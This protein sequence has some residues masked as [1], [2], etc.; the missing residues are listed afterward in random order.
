VAPNAPDEQKFSYLL[1]TQVG[2]QSY[3]FPEAFLAEFYE[4]LFGQGVK[5]AWKAE[6]D[7]AFKLQLPADS[8]AAVGVRYSQ[9][10]Q[11]VQ[12]E[13]AANKTQLPLNKTAKS[14]NTKLSASA[15]DDEKFSYMWGTDIGRQF[16]TFTAELEPKFDVDIFLQGMRD[17]RVSLKDTSKALQLSR[18]TLN[19]VGMRYQQKAVAAQ[20]AAQQK[21][22]E[23][24]AKVKEEVAGMRGD[25]LSSG[26]P[27]LMNYFVK[28]TGI[29]TEMQTLEPL[30]GKPVF[31]FYFSTTCPHCQK[32]YPEIQKIAD[33]YRSAGLTTLAIAAGS[34]TKKGILGFMEEQKAKD[35]TF[36]LDASRQFGEL[37]S[38]GYVP[39]AYFVRPNG[40]YYFYP[41]ID[42]VLDSIRTNIRTELGV[43]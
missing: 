33:E 11:K 26:M 24:Q 27:K 4:S 28:V 1:G 15:S 6:K 35:V 37:Y 40:E 32:I 13:M 34:N 41:N 7:T 19:A 12:Q 39:K 18:D 36:V 9:K 14:F 16:V 20:A 8:L 5:D 21:F 29:T 17:V 10:A 25:T 2:T 31:V 42:S 30:Q 3:G 43:K 22:Q 23:E 38:D